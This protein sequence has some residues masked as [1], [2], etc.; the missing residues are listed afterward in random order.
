MRANNDTTA[1]GPHTRNATTLIACVFGVVMSNGARAIDMPQL[2]LVSV[3]VIGVFY[4]VW[5]AK[6]QSD[7]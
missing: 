7:A 5:Q 3:L 1:L 6:G 4:H 2:F